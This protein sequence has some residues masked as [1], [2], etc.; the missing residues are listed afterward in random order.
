MNNIPVHKFP[1]CIDYD[2]FIEELEKEK[3]YN[4]NDFSN[5]FGRENYDENVPYQ[6]FWHWL[7]DGPFTDLSKGG[8]NYLDKGWLDNEGTPEFVKT[9]LTDIFD[10]VKNHPAFGGDRINFYVDSW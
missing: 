5:K 3:G 8:V 6:D 1:I 9:I 10:A 4:T 7:L 2:T